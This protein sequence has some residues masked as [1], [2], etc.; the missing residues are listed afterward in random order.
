MRPLW[1]PERQ[2]RYAQN[3]TPG[4][5]VSL[6]SCCPGRWPGRLPRRVAR[7]R[8]KNG[9]M[10][11]CAGGGALVGTR[12]QMRPR[13]TASP[14]LAARGSASWVTPDPSREAPVRWP[15]RGRR[16]YLLRPPFWGSPALPYGAG[17][18]KSRKQKQ[19]QKNQHKKRGHSYGLGILLWPDVY[20]TNRKRT[21]RK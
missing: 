14:C 5:D 15:S 3:T 20:R 12:T 16:W 10:Q 11:P 21:N 8:P 17:R 7:R 19:K 2:P 13:P 18:V 9:S 6:A 4:R 1:L